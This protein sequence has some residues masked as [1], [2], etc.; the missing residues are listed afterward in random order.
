MTIELNLGAEAP[1]AQAPSAAMLAILKAQRSGAS[2]Q[3]PTTPEAPAE[4]LK[5]ENQQDALAESLA[6]IEVPQATADTTLPE[7]AGIVVEQPE[8]AKR[9]PMPRGSGD[10]DY[11][12]GGSGVMYPEASPSDKEV[13]PD[14]EEGTM[15]EAVVVPHTESYPSLDADGNQKVSKAGKLL[16]KKVTVDGT[17]HIK[18]SPTA[19][20]QLTDDA[21]ASVLHHIMHTVDG[22]LS[23]QGVTLPAEGAVSDKWLITHFGVNSLSEVI[24]SLLTPW[25]LTGKGNKVSIAQKE[26]LLCN[27]PVEGINPA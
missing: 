17:R 12:E 6:G 3:P 22:H 23:A 7:E 8:Q 5:M 26:A 19:V 13:M 10:V 18:L 24:A 14:D 9:P 4:E 21:A 16:M 20:E 1:P 2:A 25:T 11:R 27:I 15:V